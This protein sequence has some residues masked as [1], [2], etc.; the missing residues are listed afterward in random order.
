MN[1]SPRQPPSLRS[2]LLLERQLSPADLALP[3]AAMSVGHCPHDDPMCASLLQ[4]LALMKKIDEE[5]KFGYSIGQ[6]NGDKI[7]HTHYI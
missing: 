6:P 4:M 5:N 7:Y 2:H 1:T 3:L